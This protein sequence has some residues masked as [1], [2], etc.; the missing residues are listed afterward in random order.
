MSAGD[1]AEAGTVG[2]GGVTTELTGETMH[3]LD[4]IFWENF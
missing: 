3:P 4:L 1:C 2:G